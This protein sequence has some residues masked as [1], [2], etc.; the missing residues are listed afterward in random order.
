MRLIYRILLLVLLLPAAVSCQIH[1]AEEDGSPSEVA[2]LIAKTNRLLS[3]QDFDA[4]MEKGLQ[5]LALSQDAG[6]ALGQVRALQAIVGIDIM[7]SRDED[8]WKRA[9]VHRSLLLRANG[10]LIE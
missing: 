6:D 5:A 7:A 8:A 9:L 10:V 2:Q 4:A 1:A 3:L